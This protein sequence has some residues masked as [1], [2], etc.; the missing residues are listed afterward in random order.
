M[1]RIASD[2]SATNKWDE[3]RLEKSFVNHTGK[4]EQFVSCDFID[5]KQLL[6]VTSLRV[7]VLTEDFEIKK[8][9]GA[10]TLDSSIRSID[11]CKVTSQG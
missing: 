6:L 7:I 9:V 11:C 4:K 2:S 1:I 3:K 5:E 8:Q 10:F